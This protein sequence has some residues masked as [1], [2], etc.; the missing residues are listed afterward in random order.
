[1]VRWSDASASVLPR[2]ARDD[3]ET[4][5]DAKGRSACKSERRDLGPTKHFKRLV[6]THVDLAAARSLGVQFAPVLALP[7]LPARR[8]VH[9]TDAA[10]L[11][12]EWAPEPTVVQPSLAL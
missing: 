8:L 4:R 2:S 9:R 3:E 10:G 1:M 11:K 5:R 7:Q 6:A 12:S